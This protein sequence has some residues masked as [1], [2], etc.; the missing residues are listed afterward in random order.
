MVSD[1]IHFIVFLLPSIRTHYRWAYVQKHKVQLP[2]EYDQIHRD[3]EPFW[4]ISPEDLQ[5]AQAEL[6]A[7]ANTYTFASQN[8]KFVLAISNLQSTPEHQSG[9][10]IRWEGHLK[11]L[12]EVQQWLPDF[13]ATFAMDDGPAQFIGYDL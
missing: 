8:G 4:G 9:T 2:D 10:R 3:L 7:A 5:A 6:E 13:R 11:L 1:Q 12:A